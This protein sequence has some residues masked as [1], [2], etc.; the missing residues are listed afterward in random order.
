MTHRASILMLALA[1]LAL[2]GCATQS[3]AYNTTYS[4]YQGPSPDAE[5]TGMRTGT[6]NAE[7]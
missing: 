7:Y 2:P 3:G 1:L 6:M 4:Q 5:V